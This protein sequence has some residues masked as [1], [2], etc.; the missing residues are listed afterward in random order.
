MSLIHI[1][2]LTFAYEGSF[3]NIFEEMSFAL[4]T[5]WKTGFVGRN[6]RGKTT[7]LNLLMK[8]YAYN[9]SITASVNFEYFPY[10]VPDKSLHTE[11][12]L[13]QIC[14]LAE[15]WEFMKEL[16]LL[17]LSYEVL[18]RPFNTLSNG[19]QTKALLGALFL[20]ENAFLLIDEPTNHLDIEA[21]RK[22]AEYLQG[23]NGFILISHDRAFLDASV[24]HI[25]S[26]NKANI[27]VQSGNFSS[28][29]QNKQWQDNYELVQNERL[30]KD[31]SRLNEAARRTA[32]WSDKTEKGKFA[33]TDAGLKP[34]RGAV[35]HKAAKM[36]KRSKNLENRLTQVAE[37]KSKLLK[38]IETNESLKLSPL[39]FFKDTLIELNNI[40][41][42]YGEKT[43]LENISLS[44]KNGD[45]ISLS[46]KNG[47]GKSTLM[48]LICGEDIQYKGQ[49][50]KSDRLI[51]SYVPQDTSHLFGNLSEYAGEQGLDESLFKSILRKLAFER[52]QFEKNIENFSGGQKKK[53][54]IAASLCQQAHLYVWDEPLNFIDVLSRMQIEN[55]IREFAPTLLFVEHDAAF[56]ENI[57]TNNIILQQFS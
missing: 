56:C 5:D 39:T 32:V 23:K 31:I 13:H 36:M 51:I 45:R 10:E 52:V 12:I 50:T 17:D 49:L 9:G 53:V 46:G 20:N 2:N 47:C 54:L 27:E 55:L 33:K 30:K 8:K 40:S 48:K 44:I 15:D 22:V 24:D 57:A 14:P 16:S 38:N 3:D 29:W 37:E 6:G 41:L 11:E 19:E 4:D 25:L 1:S 35:G 18:Y 26:I 28:W 7:F 34:D 43:V 21:R 42:F